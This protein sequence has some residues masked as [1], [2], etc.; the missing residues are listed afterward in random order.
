LIACGGGG[1]PVIRKGKKLIG[2][3]AVIDKDLT[4]QTLANI[5]NA[6]MLL[7]LTN[8]NY[9]YLNFGKKN[10]MEIKNIDVKKLKELYERGEFAKGSMA[11]KILACIRFIENGGKKA[12]IAHLDEFEKAFQ[13]KTGTIIEK[14]VFKK[15]KIF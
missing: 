11:P 3:E 15:Y 13:G 7:I 6:D 10:Q 2:V 12:V 14:H 5:L 4:S 1:I 8:V 9:A